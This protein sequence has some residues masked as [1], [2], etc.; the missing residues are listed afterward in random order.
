LE[1][2][3]KNR[4]VVERTGIIGLFNIH[5]EFPRDETNPYA[6]VSD[7]TG[8]ADVRISDLKGPSIFTALEQQLGLKLQPRKAFRKV[9]GIGGLERPS[10][11][12]SQT[13]GPLVQRI[14]RIPTGKPDTA[15]L[16]LCHAS[17]AYRGATRGPFEI[18][19]AVQPWRSPQESNV[20]KFSMRATGR[21]MLGVRSVCP[22]AIALVLP[23]LGQAPSA[24]PGPSDIRVE[25]DVVNILCTV[26]NWLGAYVDDLRKS[27]F[28][29]LEN[30]SHRRS[31]TSL[32]RS[33]PQ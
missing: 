23:L 20:V 13:K 30:A 4:P 1:S 22:L 8:P 3:F 5:L 6:P 2:Q 18:P 14:S 16:L 27:D 10:D 32:G 9:L 7:A 33:I 12:A 21:P 11:S 25:V 17:Q 26:R 28:E 19:D 15:N 31:V 24:N 29:I